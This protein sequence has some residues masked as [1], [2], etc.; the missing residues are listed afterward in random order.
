MISAT[1]AL[2]NRDGTLQSIYLHFGDYPVDKTLQAHYNTQA[3]VTQLLALG[4]LSK[5]A[6][7]IGEQHNYYDHH[8]QHP[9]W[10]L[11]FHRDGGDSWSL[12]KTETFDNWEH[13]LGSKRQKYT[14][15]Y[16][17]ESE[18]GDIAG[19]WYLLADEGK[20]YPLGQKY[21]YV[22]STES[23]RGDIASRW[24]LLDDEGKLYPLDLLSEEDRRKFFGN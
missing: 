4:H 5:L 7:E 1:L 3:K 19:R 6:A 2:L 11:A 13:F 20:L 14:Y 23:E 9:N 17:T 12:V 21:T 22:Y 10:T 18:R 8:C 24:Y 16:S 15:V